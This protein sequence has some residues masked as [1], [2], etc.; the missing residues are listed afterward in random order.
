MATLQASAEVMVLIY[1]EIL[2]A[3]WLLELLLWGWMKYVIILTD[4]SLY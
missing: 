2:M 1:L 4:T 3:L